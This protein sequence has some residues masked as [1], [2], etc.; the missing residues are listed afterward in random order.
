MTCRDTKERK[1]GNHTE[2][3]T[4]VQVNTGAGLDH[5]PDIMQAFS[6]KY[7]VLRTTLLCSL[8]RTKTS[9][10]IP[11][12]TTLLIAPPSKLATFLNSLLLDGTFYVTNSAIKIKP[13]YFKQGLIMRKKTSVKAQ[14]GFQYFRTQQHIMCRSVYKNWEIVWRSSADKRIQFQVTW[15][16][17]WSTWLMYKAVGYHAKPLHNEW[18]SNVFSLWYWIIKMCIG[19][20]SAGL[21]TR[22]FPKACL[23]CRCRPGKTEVFNSWLW[24]EDNERKT[25]SSLEIFLSFKKCWKTPTPE[26]QEIWKRRW[27]DCNIHRT[28]TSVWDGVFYIWQGSYTHKILTICFLK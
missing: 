6:G 13:S 22:Y 23:L 14:S 7:S 12:V 26:A 1:L 24:E 11:F 19:V 2:G 25:V 9:I 4:R 28:K 17:S 10:Y 27:K 18:V 8:D 3:Y 15:P 5:V 21:S 20:T 16:W